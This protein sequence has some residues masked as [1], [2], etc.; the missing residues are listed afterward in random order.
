MGKK[1]NGVVLSEIDP[2]EMRWLWDKWLPCGLVGFIVGEAKVG[3]STVLRDLIARITRDR[4]MPDGSACGAPGNVIYIGGEELQAETIV[5]GLIAAGADMS[6]VLDMTKVEHAVTAGTSIWSHFDIARDKALLKENIRLFG[7]SLVMI[8]PFLAAV[9]AKTHIWANQVAS[10]VFLELQDVAETTGACILIVN[11]FTKMSRKDKTGIAL[12]ECMLGG[13][14][15]THRTRFALYLGK[16]ETD[17]GRCVLSSIVHS[18]APDVPPITLR[19]NGKQV[20]YLTG[21][22]EEKAEEVAVQAEKSNRAAIREHLEVNARVAYPPQ[23][24]AQELSVKHGKDFD[25]N[26]VKSLLRR[27]ADAGE[28][29]RVGD[30]GFYQAK[31]KPRKKP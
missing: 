7:A 24:V 28:I 5:P 9:S 30:R 3:K 27:M 15:L 25:Y 12:L 29:A 31:P 4:E 1:L 10:D 22:T 23:R 11:H 26:T 18:N 20:H 2:E 13:A 14:S 19:H 16:D 8:D 6:K 17:P 21:L